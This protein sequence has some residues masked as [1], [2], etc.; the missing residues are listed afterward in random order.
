MEELILV[1]SWAIVLGIVTIWISPD[2]YTW[3]R[4]RGKRKASC[5]AKHENIEQLNSELGG[6]MQRIS[7]DSGISTLISICEHIDIRHNDTAKCMMI[8]G[9]CDVGKIPLAVRGSREE[10][11]KVMAWYRE[12]HPQF[13]YWIAPIM[14]A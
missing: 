11:E 4:V 13:R 9:A 5:G 1:A 12:E 14:Q 8:W 7:S 3:W 10:A 2:V 6:M